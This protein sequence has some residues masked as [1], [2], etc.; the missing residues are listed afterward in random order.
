MN[1]SKEVMLSKLSEFAI[2]QALPAFE[3]QISTEASPLFEKIKKPTLVSP[4]IEVFTGVGFN[5]GFGFGYEGGGIPESGGQNYELF[6]LAAADMLG[7]VEI[8]DK[9][10]QLGLNRD[11]VRGQQLLLK[12]M[13]GVKDALNFNVGR[14]LFGNGKGILCTVTAGSADSNEVVVSDVKNLRIGFKIDIYATGGTTPVQA[15]RRITSID[16]KNKKITVDGAK[17]TAVAGFITLQNSYGKEIFGIGS[18]FDSSIT[19]IYGVSKSGNS[20]L[21]P[22][23]YDADNSITD[24]LLSKAVRESATYKSSDIDM[25]LCGDTAFDTYYEYMK[26]SNTVISENRVFSGGVA[27]M[28]ILVDGR[29]VTVVH[30]KHVG[31][32]E[33]IGVDTTKLYFPRTPAEFISANGGNIFQRIDNSTKYQAVLGSYG[34]LICTNPGGLFKVTNVAPASSGT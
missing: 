16:R 25:L 26:E 3:N 7:T 15:K 29:K 34:N 18:F 14:A 5:G 9:A 30:E 33:I 22:E 20:W 17:F 32:S 8:T 10:L 12:E 28:D 2:N 11:G 27:G 23:I 4:T 13:T 31:D 1:I 6:K 19:S 21:T 24:T